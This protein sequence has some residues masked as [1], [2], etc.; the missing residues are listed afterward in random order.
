MR[1]ELKIIVSTPENKDKFPCNIQILI[2]DQPIGFIQKFKFE[3]DAYFVY[4]KIEVELPN[5]DIYRGLTTHPSYIRIQQIAEQLKE[6]PFIEVS[7]SV[8][9]TKENLADQISE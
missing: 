1:N 8:G 4:P 9:S 7:H 3:A 5:L 6:F 2:D